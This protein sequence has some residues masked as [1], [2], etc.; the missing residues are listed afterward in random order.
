MFCK[1]KSCPEIGYAKILDRASTTCWVEFFHSPLDDGREVRE[2]ALKDVKTV[3]LNPNV[4][5]Y[6]W[7]PSQNTWSVGRVLHDGDDQLVVRF[8]NRN[9]ALVPTD[10]AFVRSRQPISDP[11]DYLGS[12]ITESPLFAD[13]RGAFLKSYIE[14]RAVTNG[15]SALLSSTIELLPHQVDVVR[16]VLQDPTQR[17]LLADEVGLGKT[18]EAGLIIRQVVLDNPENHHVVV[19]VPPSL[20]NQWKDEL[21][22]RFGLEAYLDDSVVIVGYDDDFDIGEHLAKAQ[23]L[24]IDEAHHLAIEGEYSH[25][26]TSLQQASKNADG[27]LLLSATPVLGNERGFLRM[28]H[29]LDPIVFALEDEETFSS[30]IRNRQGLAEAVAALVP[31]NALQL[32][33]VLEDLLE[34]LP[35]DVLLRELA[36]PLQSIV[37]EIP[38]EDDPQFLKALRTVRTHVSETHRLHRRILRNRRKQLPLITPD[39]SGVTAWPA[40]ESTL[41][42]V[43]QAIE[44]WRANASASVFGNDTSAALS[45]LTKFY[46]KLIHGLFETPGELDTVCLDRMTHISVGGTTFEGENN[47]LSTIARAVR[48]FDELERL[49]VLAKHLEKA[50]MAP[51]CKVVV[52]CSDPTRANIVRDTLSECLET[53]V[54]RHSG[55]SN[56]SVDWRAFLSGQEAR[57]LVC[58][59]ESEEGLNLQGGEKLVVHYDLPLSPNRV[60]QRMGRVDRFGTG[61]SVKSYVLLDPGCRVVTEWFR[62]LDDSLGVFDRS[63]ASLQYMVQDEVQT[64][65]RTIFSEG[66]EAITD[67]NEKFSG[68]KGA[69]AQEFKRI[70][71]QDDLDALASVLDES[72]EAIDTIDVEWKT[73][74]DSFDGWLNKIL[75]FEKI[76]EGARNEPAVEHP[77]RFRCRF[78]DSGRVA[79]ISRSDMLENFIQAI[80]FEAEGSTSEHPLSY[81]Y[82]YRRQTAI[83]KNARV[84]RYGDPF[85]EAAKQF[86]EIDDRGRSWA[87]WR[88]IHGELGDEQCGWYFSFN[89]VVE[90]QTD[91]ALALLG[92]GSIGVS[93][94]TR[95]AE[96]LFAPIMMQTWVT[97]DGKSVVNEFSE[98]FLNH[99]YRKEGETAFEDTNLNAMRW[100]RIYEQDPE[101][102][103]NWQGMCAGTRKVAMDILS[104]DKD[105]R[106]RC[107]NAL[108]HAELR[109]ESRFAQLRSRIQHLSGKAAED[110]QRNLGWEKQ[111]YEA[112]CEGIREPSISIDSV[113]AVFLS[114]SSFSDFLA[115]SKEFSAE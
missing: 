86:T 115:Q 13:A 30:R 36:L 108:R 73:I 54:V 20:K 105:F 99:P 52:F 46:I 47:F 6:V 32:D 11:T 15:L 65:E 22:F 34:Q 106:Q 100:Q 29:L 39:R 45:E 85:A 27:L 80:D 49:S 103:G 70:G 58:D 28:L 97:E 17:Y 89:F 53:S 1:L 23:F 12:F 38:S 41:E 51:R 55:H 19:L 82:A 81:L 26:Y 114:T 33:M 107:H 79:L 98:N 75:Q 68:E 67:L 50:L 9:D 63:I 92:P 78:G 104:H 90:I 24:V 109:S 62:L 40:G 87:M 3:E 66:L 88:H 71:Q 57:V 59:R 113:G 21:S 96:A 18:I 44:D 10:Q 48:N 8:P 60:E 14:Q 37:A 111:L 61:D 2:V 35:N 16:T 102:V 101:L 112:L 77:F 69:V 74:R 94:I 56:V 43:E 5:V 64:L 76:P 4:R 93:A 95:R 83:A 91:K 84:M 72:I 25:L 31:E 42:Q 110:E 7:S